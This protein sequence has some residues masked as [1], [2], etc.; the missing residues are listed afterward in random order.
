MIRFGLSFRRTDGPIKFSR[1]AAIPWHGV[2]KRRR[3]AEVVRSTMGLRLNTGKMPVP[4]SCLTLTTSR[5]S[6]TIAP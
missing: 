3:L 1:G 2:A 5:Y 4:R 6:D